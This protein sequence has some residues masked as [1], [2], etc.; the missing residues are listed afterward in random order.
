M[1]FAS[2][3]SKLR[4]DALTGL[5]FFAALAVY[6]SHHPQ[7][8][9]MPDFLATFFKA[10]YNGVTIFFVLSGFVIGLNYIESLSTPSFRATARYFIARIARV[11]PLYII[12]LLFIWLQRQAPQD[13]GLLW[14]LL[15]IQG[16]SP[17]LAFAYGY[18]SPGW[19]VGVEF[20]LYLCFPILAL[21]FYPLRKSEKTLWLLVSAVTI[22]LFLIAW[23]LLQ[24][25]Q[26][27]LPWEDPASAHRWLYRT[28]LL[29]L[30]DFCLGILGALLFRAQKDSAT[31]HRR[32]WSVVSYGA[33]TGIIA[34]MMIPSNIYS[35]Y[36][37]DAL[38][39]PL[40]F[41]LILGIALVPSTL[42]GRL[43]ATPSIVLLGEASY[44]LYLIHYHMMQTIFRIF[45]YE[46]YAPPVAIA[47]WLAFFGICILLSLALH[48]YVETPIRRLMN[49]YA[50]R[51]L[52]AKSS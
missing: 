8:D 2:T 49:A 44:A 20:F 45:R 26:A 40:A 19:S 23:G 27:D 46:A 30:G 14:H 17:D 4:L 3:K 37:W 34:A 35:V 25:G 41:L 42:L 21:I 33:A 38:Y 24:N 6:Q 52:E 29:R 47:S 43:L 16:W 13:I 22:A 15:T 32:T 7:P 39:A 48:T 11:Y 31:Q 51:W 9:Y 1:D 12:V 10:G 5:R 36:S 18:N 28:P 50:E